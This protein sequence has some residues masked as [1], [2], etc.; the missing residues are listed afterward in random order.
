MIRKFNL[1]II[2]YEINEHHYGA[3]MFYFKFKSKKNIKNF[4]PAIE[5]KKTTSKSL[6]YRF[7]T[8]QLYINNL[9]E[10]VKNY[11]KEN[12]KFML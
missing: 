1:E 6:N 11:K 3:L 8:Y 5:R 7:K 9:I 2:D 10:L 12:I 4:L